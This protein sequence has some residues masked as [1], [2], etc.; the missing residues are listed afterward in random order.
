MKGL[1]SETTME[2]LKDLPVK[3]LIVTNSIDQ[4]DRIKACNGTLETIDIAP[5]IAESIRRTHNG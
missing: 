2:S 4:S 3:K 1:L 5:V